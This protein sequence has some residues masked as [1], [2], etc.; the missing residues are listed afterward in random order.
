M[1]DCIRR[2]RHL[3]G[4]L[5]FAFAGVMGSAPVLAQEMCGGAPYP[6]PYT[7]VAGVGAAF[8]PGI[9]EAYVTGVSKG[10]SPTTFTPNQSV[11]R[12]QMTTFL[13]RALDA[14]LAR[15]SRR[16]ALDQWWPQAQGPMIPVGGAPFTCSA[17]G[18]NIW[19]STFTGNTLVEVQASTGTV[20]GTW[21]EIPLSAGVRV[22]A[23][24]VFVAGGKNFGASS[25][26]GLFII[27]PSQPPSN[28]FNEL[29][30]GNQ[31]IGVAYDGLFVWTANRGPPGSVSI[32]QLRDARVTTV[33]T[34]FNAPYG[35]LFDGTNIWVTDTGAGTLLKL[36]SAG[37]I[38]QTV[39]VGAL[40]GFPVFDGTNIW[41][42]NFND[43]SVT[44]VQ[45]RTGT[46]VATILADG[47][48]NLNGP[49]GA[50]FDGERVLIANYGNDTV[51][52]FKAA[53][54]SVILNYYVD[55]GFGTGQ[56][57]TSA[58][59]DGINFWVPLQS[60]GTLLRF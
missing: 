4:L 33:T 59:S 57:P 49:N 54:L 18:E 20:L 10:T 2:S 34:G 9:M 12:V 41:V 1:K 56:A 40:P 17:D 60:N 5:G 26:G 24:M 52:L 31:P 6:F 8:C 38:V 48:N 15:A 37:T 50:S 30:V 36:D 39:T 47:S 22:A 32:V 35:I 19:I 16:A 7:D 55:D 14:G 53:D 28:G 13:Q 45:A 3:L 11:P 51:T 46:V 42:P 44:V 58:C 43:N 23:G 27:D 29:D 25:P 21:S